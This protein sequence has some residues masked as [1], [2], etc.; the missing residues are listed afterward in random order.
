VTDYVI[1]GKW[2]NYVVTVD[3]EDFDSANNF[4]SL[5]NMFTHRMNPG[6][7]IKWEK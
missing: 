5:M 6:D 3:G 7:T 2:P 4:A 1:R